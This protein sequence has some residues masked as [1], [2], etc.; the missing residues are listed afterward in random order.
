[1]KLTLPEPP[2]PGGSYRSVT[3]RG[4][5]AYVAIQ[6]PILNGTFPFKGRLGDTISTEQGYEAAKLCALNILSQ[7]QKHIGFRKIEG[8]N[9]LDIYYQQTDGWD[10]GPSVADGAS[11]TFLEVLGNSGWHTRS[12]AGV[13]NLPRNFCVGIVSNFTIH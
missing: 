5:I 1:M 11:S 6:F 8:L 10:D 7:I 9:H 2:S 13:Q 4:N 3:I 12:I